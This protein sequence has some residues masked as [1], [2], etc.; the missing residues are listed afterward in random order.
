MEPHSPAG[1]EWRRD[2]AVLPVQSAAFPGPQ[3]GP[4]LPPPRGNELRTAGR[5]SSRSRLQEQESRH[6]GA[7]ME[8]AG[9]GGG[10][11]EMNGGED[12]GMDGGM[13]VH[14]EADGWRMGG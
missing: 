2:V 13:E 3:S 10:S 7:M 5:R 9:K 4:L 1:G 14:R 12:G 8:A 6:G 11:R